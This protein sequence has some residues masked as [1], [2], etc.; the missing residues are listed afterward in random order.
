MSGWVSPGAPS[1]ASLEAASLAPPAPQALPP[2]LAP[3][4]LPGP[5]RQML[6]AS[7]QQQGGTPGPGVRW[8]TVTIYRPGIVPLRPLAA[9]E[10][11]DGAFSLLRDNLLVVLALSLPLALVLRLLS[12][13]TLYLLAGITTTSSA[14][15]VTGLIT[16]V[17]GAVLVLPLAGALAALAGD[18]V[19]GVRLPAGEALRRAVR[20]RAG[21]FRLTLI[22]AAVLLVPVVVIVL[23]SVSGVA[24]G[25]GFAAVV[26]TA[27]VLL[28]PWAVVRWL[29][30]AP[31]AV[32]L[33]GAG[34][35]GALRRARHLTRRAWW[36]VAGLVLLS[37]AITLLLGTLLGLPFR[38][39]GGV[40]S[41]S[42]GGLRVDGTALALATVGGL[43]ADTLTRP[44][45]AGSLAIAYLD[46]RMRREG[47]DL[48]LS[49]R[50]AA[51]SQ[52]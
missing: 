36:R 41:S 19:L 51:Q 52:G 35:R 22:A 20:P 1:V 18:A 3:G 5:A 14:T 38:L 47:L 25:G 39:D 46:Q 27:S 10:V 28:L 34:A 43:L 42:G 15:S 8:D 32:A 50:V 24:G 4:P 21:L 17:A 11:L 31:G 37:A 40:T 44:I 45:L 48:T 7:A 2:H 16:A 33:E 12:V 13:G 9:G 49:R 30:L 23:L 6:P 29:V 26:A